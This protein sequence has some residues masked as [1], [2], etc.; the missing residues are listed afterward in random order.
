MKKSGIE[1]KSFLDRFIFAKSEST[2][3]MDFGV[4]YFSDGSYEGAGGRDGAVKSEPRGLILFSNNKFIYTYIKTIK[5]FV[6][7]YQDN[8]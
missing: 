1:E 7:N 4:K 8:N 6:A 2:G 5:E 3:K